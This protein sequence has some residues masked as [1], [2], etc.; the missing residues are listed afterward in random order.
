MTKTITLFITA[1]LFTCCGFAQ[2]YIEPIAGYQVD[3]NNTQKFKQINSGV[4]FSF[5]KSNR[6]ELLMLLQRSWPVKAVSNDSAF[7]A[8][9]ALP[10]YTNAEKT[11]RPS[12]SSFSIGH[13]IKIAG[14][15]SAN[16][17]SIILYTGV[18]CQKF[19]ISY[20]YDKNNYSILNPDKT[21]DKIGFVIGESL[22]YMRLVEN[23][24]IFFQVNI[25]TPPSGKRINYPATFKFMAPLAFN[26]GYSL[27]IQNKKNEKKKN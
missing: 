14:K 1:T 6:Y 21:L 18:A 2:I 23:G 27:Q 12:I 15:N 24:R 26:A 17:F 13:R 16:I 25:F 20:N 9:P 7:T 11:I 22:E 4:Q 5:K 3:L 8:N 10:V 19:G